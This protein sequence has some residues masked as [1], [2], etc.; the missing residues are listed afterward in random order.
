MQ[1]SKVTDNIKRA[2]DFCLRDFKEKWI[3]LYLAESH[4]K[5]IKKHNLRI[6]LLS[7]ETHKTIEEYR[8]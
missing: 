1:N 7:N 8:A 4:D 6:L 2:P 5:F 3:I